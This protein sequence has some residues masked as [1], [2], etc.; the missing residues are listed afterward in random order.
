MSQLP[1]T[2]FG[3]SHPTHGPIRYAHPLWQVVALLELSIWLYGPTL[4]QLV[5]QWWHDPN[6]SHS[7]FV[8]TFS[9][10]VVG[11]DALGS[12]RFR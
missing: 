3:A 5:R 8:P 1:Q 4:I 11:R 12:R 7:I 2:E 9:A 6:F 10:F